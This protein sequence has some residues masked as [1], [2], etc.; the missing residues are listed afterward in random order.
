MSTG[1]GGFL[2]GQGAVQR[3]QACDTV[4]SW[5]SFSNTGEIAG[6]FRDITPA[7]V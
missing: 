5:A 1:T 6:T 3:V 2:G 4:V 7:E